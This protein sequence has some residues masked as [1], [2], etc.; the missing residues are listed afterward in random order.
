MGSVTQTVAEVQ[1]LAQTATVV[2]GE[3]DSVSALLNASVEK[4]GVQAN[5]REV[6][7]TYAVSGEARLVGDALYLNAALDAGDGPEVPTLPEGWFEV[8][9]PGDYPY[10]NLGDLRHAPSVL[11]DE[12]Q[13]P[14]PPMSRSK[15]SRWKTVRAPTRSR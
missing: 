3:T 11:D 1:N 14:P 8:L 5:G 13:A 6:V 4:N 10:L 9:N 15:R 2:Q 7:T 12:Q